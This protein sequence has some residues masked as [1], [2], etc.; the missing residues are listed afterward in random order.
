MK[1]GDHI[2]PLKFIFLHPLYFT[3]NNFVFHVSELPELQRNACPPRWRRGS[4]WTL[5]R[6]IRVR[7]SA[8]IT[9]CGPSD[10][11]E[12]KRSSGVPVPVSR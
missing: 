10:G 2:S 3:D 8:Y 7:F 11:K 6:K 4:T 1:P 12:V 5:D 9:A